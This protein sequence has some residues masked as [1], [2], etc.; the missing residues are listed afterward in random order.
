MSESY[1]PG[2]KAYIDG[3]KAHIYR[4]NYALRA[5]FL[6]PGEHKVEFVYD[7]WTFKVGLIITA[8]TICIVG[9]FLIRL[10]ARSDDCENFSG[11]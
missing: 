5:L 9:F 10:K 8:I 4:A 11:Q 3:Q 6:K 1:Y 2:W 7:P